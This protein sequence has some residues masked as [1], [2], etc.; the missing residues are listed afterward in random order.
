MFETV[1]Q[2]EA[3]QASVRN[4]GSQGVPDSPEPWVPDV[5]SDFT[6]SFGDEVITSSAPAPWAKFALVAS[7]TRCQPPWQACFNTP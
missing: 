6:P 3:L 2:F 4:S 7:Q 5:V 1:R